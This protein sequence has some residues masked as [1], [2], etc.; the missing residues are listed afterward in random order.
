MEAKISIFIG[1]RLAGRH[2]YSIPAKGTHV[3]Q[4]QT[5]VDNREGLASWTEKAEG[6]FALPRQPSS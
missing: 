5:V 6:T 1:I 4:L 3:T 2:V